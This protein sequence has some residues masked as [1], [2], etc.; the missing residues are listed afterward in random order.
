MNKKG[1]NILSTAVPH[2]VLEFL[3][4][5]SKD[6]EKL[7]VFSKYKDVIIQAGEEPNVKEFQTHLLI[8]SARSPRFEK[9]LWKMK[10]N[11]SMIYDSDDKLK[12]KGKD[13]IFQIPSKEVWRNIRPY[14]Q[15]IPKQ[16]YQNIIGHHLDPK[17]PL[18]ETII[19]PKRNSIL[20]S[21]LIEDKH[22]DII[23]GWI[24]DKDDDVNT[25][26]ESKPYRLFLLYRAS[27]DGF[28]I[29]KF[30]LLCDKKGPTVFI[31]HLKE[32]GKLIGGYNPFSLEPYNFLSSDNFKSRPT[33][34]GGNDLTIKDN[35]IIF[36]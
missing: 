30:H 9:D 2:I 33:F 10:F 15:L 14:Q 21:K 11:K 4:E 27:R 36:S 8:L 22:L 31:A 16:F 29:S 26:K 19:L 35:L 7:L 17:T 25:K 1:N 6:I 32:S 34:G 12:E 23:N 3:T 5:F 13:M 24:C 18:N 28:K 20:N